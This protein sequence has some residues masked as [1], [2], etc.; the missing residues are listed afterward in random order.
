MKLDSIIDAKKRVNFELGLDISKE[1]LN[2]IGK[3][4]YKANSDDIKW[5]EYECKNKYDIKKWT[6]FIL[7]KNRIKLNSIIIKMR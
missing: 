6:I 1:D 4:I 7:L 5:G 3:I 2:L